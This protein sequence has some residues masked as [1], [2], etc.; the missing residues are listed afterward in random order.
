[1]KSRLHTRYLNLWSKDKETILENLQV[2]G[3][4][5]NLGK[6]NVC[7]DTDG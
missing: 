6:S 4:Q 1:M 5:D 7:R 2:L 3:E